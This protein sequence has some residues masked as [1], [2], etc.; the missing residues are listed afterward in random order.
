MGH[1]LN[2]PKANANS[3]PAKFY[4]EAG[5]PQAYPMGNII[6]LH[7]FCATA[8]NSRAFM[9]DHR[10]AECPPNN[11]WPGEL[12]FNNGGGGTNIGFWIKTPA[13]PT[14]YLANGPHQDWI[15]VL[16]AHA[17]KAGVALHTFILVDGRALLDGININS[18]HWTYG[19]TVSTGDAFP[20]INLHKTPP[21]VYQPFAVAANVAETLSR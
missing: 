16:I 9:G 19:H 21:S 1:L 5:I 10:I 18:A 13:E 8:M 6:R 11:A 12:L 7:L 20:F 17:T 15:E 4:R 14:P 2:L 3:G